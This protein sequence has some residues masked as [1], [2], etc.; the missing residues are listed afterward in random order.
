MKVLN[1]KFDN[2]PVFDSNMI[3]FE[4]EAKDCLNTVV[5]A[6]IN[7]SGKTTLLYGVFKAFSK[8][9]ENNF[10][11]DEKSDVI[12]ELEYNKEELK[13]PP[14]MIY[15]PSEV[16]FQNVHS[17][18]QPSI[19]PLAYCI[20]DKSTYDIISYIKQTFDKQ[21]FSN[22][23]MTVGQ[24]I[25]T[26]CK[27]INSIFTILE[28]DV[29]LV[30]IKDPMTKMPLFRNE[31]G[32]EFDINGLSSGEKQLFIRVISL[33][34]LE[35]EGCVILIDEPEISL[36]PSWQQRIVEV[37]QNIGKDNQIIIAT[38]SPHIISSIKRES[39]KI[40][41]KKERWVKVIDGEDL[42][43]TYGVTADMILLDIMGL[44]TT[45]HPHIQEQIDELKSMVRND[46]Y[47]TD[48]FKELYESITSVIGT[49]DQDILLVNIEIARR[50]GLRNAGH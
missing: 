35:P 29:F 37:Y 39:L 11:I 28:M 23:D 44:S 21:I 31:A 46:L 12:L 9:V 20:D 5:L 30:G 2:H 15:L 3:S 17:S 4:T 48:E 19:L 18:T 49:I 10:E 27:K 47:D 8:L 24:S 22:P 40:L 38:H 41:S 1:V 25:S 26:V 14:K 34:S 13:K 45:R 16:K 33:K 32:V 42:D 43:E 7:G 50:K 36:H 6:G